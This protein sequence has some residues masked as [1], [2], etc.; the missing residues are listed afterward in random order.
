MGEIILDPTFL[1]W[2]QMK[3]GMAGD[4]EGGEGGQMGEGDEEGEPGEGGGGESEEMDFE[5]LLAQYEGEGEEEDE[6][7]EPKKKTAKKSMNSRKWEYR[8]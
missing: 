7:E 8:L 4:M 1:Q 3:T 2:A 5:Q 6:E